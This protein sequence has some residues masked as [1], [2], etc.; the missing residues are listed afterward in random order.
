[1]CLCTAYLS[2]PFTYP[3]S[4]HFTPRPTT[5]GAHNTVQV[6]CAICGDT[7]HPTRDCRM[8]QG[9]AGAEGGANKVR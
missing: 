1:M 5:A 7:S 3:S 9:G 4:H 6:K 2:I 8:G